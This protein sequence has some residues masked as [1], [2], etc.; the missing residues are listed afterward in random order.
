MTDDISILFSKPPLADTDSDYIVFN[1]YLNDNTGGTDLFNELIRFLYES[2]FL[3]LRWF[4]LTLNPI[5]IIFFINKFNILG[6]LRASND[7]RLLED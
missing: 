4:R 7:L 1:Y 2:Y 6:H 5:K 3:R